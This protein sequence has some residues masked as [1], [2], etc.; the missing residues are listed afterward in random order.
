M[1]FRF[2]RRRKVP[3]IL[4]LVAVIFYATETHVRQ[5]ATWAQDFLLQVTG[6]VERAIGIV[7]V[8]VLVYFLYRRR[9]RRYP[10]PERLAVIRSAMANR[11]DIWMV[12]FTFYRKTFSER[13]V[14][15]L[16]I[17]RGI[18]LRAFDHYHGKERTFKISRI[19]DLSEIPK[20]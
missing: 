14:T 17:E 2:V 18:Y 6:S 3:F 20:A 8:L 4:V 11:R 5:L 9:D 16:K 15:P 7:V 19:K 1:A 13:T 10:V 12:Y